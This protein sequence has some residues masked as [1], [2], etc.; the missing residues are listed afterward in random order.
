MAQQELDCVI[1]T[2][3]ENVYYCSGS[4][5]GKPLRLAP[6]IIPLDD[7]PVFGV[8][9][10]EEVTARRF[11]WIDDI[12]VYK[13]GEWLPLAVWDFISDI[14]TKKGLTNSKIGMELLDIPGLSYEHIKRKILHRE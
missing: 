2:S 10:N 8:H 13:G 9:A 6:V 3:R 7:D 1:A 14:I 5:I 4:D 12:I 11:S